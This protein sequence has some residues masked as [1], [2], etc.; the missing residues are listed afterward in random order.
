MTLPMVH[1]PTTQATEG[2]VRFHAAPVAAG[3]LAAFLLLVVAAGCE[4]AGESTERHAAVEPGEEWN[5]PGGRWHMVTE[6]AAL[7]DEQREEFAKLKSIGYL[8]G[9][10]EVPDH[11]GITV[12]D[13]T[14]AYA[15]LNLYTSGHF[16]G[17]I[18][19]DMRGNVLHEWR[20]EF[21]EA[22]KTGPRAE[23]P[24]STKGAGF[25]RR[26][27]LFENGD[28]LAIFDGMAL[29][30]LDR[31]SKLIWAYLEGAH[32]DL[33]VAEDGTIYVLIREP[34]IVPRI[35]PDHAVL[36]DFVAVLD[37]DGNEIRRVPLLE[38]FENSAYAHML[39]G[40][41][42]EGD[43]FHTNTIE[44]LDGRLAG[45][46]PGFE[47]GNVLVCPRELD[48]IAVVDLEREVVVWGLEAPWVKPHQ[49]TVL[50][51]GRIMIFDNRGN[52]GASRVMEFDP[53]TQDILWGYQTRDPF[54]FYSKECGSNQRLPNG[55]TIITESD[56]GRA[57]EV[58]PR[59]GIVWEF[60]N[61][62][63]AGA[64]NEFIASVFEM[65]RLEPDFPLDW[66]ED[67]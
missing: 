67:R 66:L 63:H 39:E 18:L 65:I 26:V 60:V 56:R 50:P 28:I 9:S 38:A 6:E 27:H 29:V 3:L 58:T 54:D 5:D 41:K 10:T 24:R 35:N 4:E 45:R 8:G 36:V 52:G 19:M 44:I 40:M 48:L 1:Q 31:N 16:P 61:Q 32:H 34:A 49:P 37:S 33:E 17:A 23:L 59:R 62:A 42:D 12:H 22:W 13:T 55:N 30:K 46:V 51:N 57:F 53:V 64:D 7:T 20:Y 47:S 25:W 43:I 21:I 15:G 11:T 2:R 14:R